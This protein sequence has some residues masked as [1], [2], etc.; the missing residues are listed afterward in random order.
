MG[1]SKGLS[2]FVALIYAVP[3][4]NIAKINHRREDGV[5]FELISTVS[6]VDTVISKHCRIQNDN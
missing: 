6:I 4:Q 1:S 3:A 5:V 2:S